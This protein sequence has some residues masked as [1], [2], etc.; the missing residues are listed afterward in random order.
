MPVQ[1]KPF[2]L[3]RLLLESEG[4]VVKRE[5]LRDALWP[6]DTFVDFEHGVNVAIRKLRHAL[7]DS[8]DHPKFIETLPKLGYRFIVP[9]EW[10]PEPSDSEGL[11]IVVPML[12]PDP[13]QETSTKELAN[14]RW[15]RIAAFAVI[16]FVAILSATFLIRKTIRNPEPVLTAVP[17]TALT[18]T[19]TWSS[20]S[21]DGQ[22]VAFAWD[23]GLGW[24]QSELFVQSVGGSGPPLQ[25]THT[26]APAILG[27]AL[28]AWT[29]DG[30]WITYKRYRPESDRR[31]IEIVLT[32]APVGGP[33]IVLQ[34][35]DFADCGLS[36]SPDGKYLA[37][38]DRDLPQEPYSIFL[39]QRDTMERRRLT[40]PPKGMVG[41]DAYAIFSHDGK[42]IAFLRNLNGVSQLAVLALSSGSIQIVASGPGTIFSSLAWA[43][44]DADIVYASDVGGFSRLWK[45]AAAGG[46]PRPLGIGEDGWAPTVSQEAH[47][48]AYGRGSSDSNIW[49]IR[50]GKDQVETR[51][52]LVASSR[53]DLQP[54]FSPDESKIVFTSDRSGSA[55]IWLSDSNGNS[56]M[57][58]THL[59]SDSTG[60]PRWSP[61]GK[62]IAFDSRAHGKSS[63]YLVGL[64]GG[65]PRPITGDSFDDLMP[66]WSA[67][68]KW[69]YYQ[70]NRSGEMQVWKVPTEGGQAIQVTKQGGALALETPNGNDLY[71]IIANKDA[72]LWHRDLRS[73]EEHRVVEVPDIPDYM[74]YQITND[75]LYFTIP[76]ASGSHAHSPHSVLRYFSFA[77]RKIRTVTTLGSMM[78][79]HGIAVSRDGRTILYSQQDHISMNIM[80]VENFH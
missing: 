2:Q 80:L 50:F 34:R 29:P 63:I 74:S 76:E 61:D 46:E 79:T 45:V 42:R 11:H 20:F 75:G 78:E 54:E 64:D 38:S 12:R 60:S 47:R 35:T 26:M 31:P 67:D 48:L 8:P 30:K 23:K 71:Y 21:P 9:V 59:G 55:E 19:A 62:L 65:A 66:N 37:F 36:W 28:T 16:G 70:S 5:Q 15:K 32:P 58:I 69:I 6:A 49:R 39:L 13:E 24:P 73:D 33:E 56:P 3:L 53:Q 43:P 18:G 68:G 14:H 10:V 27:S 4:K 7:G 44:E 41:G 77:T 1:E 40:H 17:L 25:L 57:Q 72:E 52:T 51:D 22:Q